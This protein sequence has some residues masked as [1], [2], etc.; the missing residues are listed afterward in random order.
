[1]SAPRGEIE[2]VESSREQNQGAGAQDDFLFNMVSLCATDEIIYKVV[3]T[4]YY[5]QLMQEKKCLFFFS[6]LFSSLF[7]S[8]VSHSHLFLLYT[9]SLFLLR[10]FFC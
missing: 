7:L 1:M 4:I 10:S 2:E 6:F 9:R 5:V 8:A 3:N